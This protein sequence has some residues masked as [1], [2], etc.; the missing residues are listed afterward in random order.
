MAEGKK[1]SEGW[2]CLA[3]IVLAVLAYGFRGQLAKQGINTTSVECAVDSINSFY[4]SNKVI[5]VTI[6]NT[7]DG[8]QSSN[9]L[10][11]EIRRLDGEIIRKEFEPPSLK[12]GES[13]TGKLDKPLRS[14]DTVKFL[15]SSQKGACRA[16]VKTG[17][18]DRFTEENLTSKKE[19]LTPGAAGTLG[20]SLLA[21]AH[22]T[23]TFRSVGEYT[24]KLKS[25]NSE[26]EFTIPVQWSGGFTGDSYQSIFV[27]AIT[28]DGL[29]S[30]SVASDTAAIAFD[31]SR[32]DR[33]ASL[34]KSNCD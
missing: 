30:L 8:E 10:E 15:F 2:G 27:L 7:D 12:P 20:R 9:H 31:Q 17:D 14:V 4:C 16:T 3:L 26:I 33:M 28:K 22:P 1:T 11:L 24:M 6:K 5:S 23:G 21:A 34:L 19:L 25:E 29:Q 32:I 13:W 18:T